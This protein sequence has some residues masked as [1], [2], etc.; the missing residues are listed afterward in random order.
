M[1]SIRCPNCGAPPPS[2]IQ[3]TGQFNY[4]CPYCRHQAVL[5]T[6]EPA[7]PP[8]QQG[9]T[10]ILVQHGDQDDDHPH[11]HH[12]AVAVARA[13]GISWVVWMVVILMVSLGGSAGAFMKC[14]R[15]SELVSSLVWNGS[16][17]LSCSGN[18]NISVRGV[19]ANFN[20]GTA[21]VATGNCQFRCTDC[22]ISA[23]TA[24]EASS[25]AQVTIV[26]GAIQGTTLLADASG[27]ARVNI[28]GNV[29]SSGNVRESG[30][31]KVSA[32]TP[33]TPP[34]TTASAVQPPVA[35]VTPAGK[36]TPSTPAAKAAPKPKSSK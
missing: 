24:I 19:E 6:P 20:S 33:P 14:S 3:Q 36:K 29:T 9:P 28:S 23:P 32:P 16:E 22:K 35:T 13:G 12:A 10:F 1:P 11:H 15:H 34:A 5:G 8:S 18:D 4:T 26:N 25:N 17:P 31:A 27:N 7:A 2:P 30:N 21:I